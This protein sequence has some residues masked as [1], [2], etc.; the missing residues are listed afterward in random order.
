MEAVITNKEAAAALRIS[1]DALYMRK[2]RASLPLTRRRT[3]RRC[4]VCLLCE[5]GREETN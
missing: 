1:G 4:D 3:M 2:K 5:N